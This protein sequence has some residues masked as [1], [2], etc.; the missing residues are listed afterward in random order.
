MEEEVLLAAGIPPAANDTS[1]LLDHGEG[2]KIDVRRAGAVSPGLA[3][4]SSGHGSSPREAINDGDQSSP[5][6]LHEELSAPYDV[7]LT[8]IQMPVM[9]KN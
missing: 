4:S 2:H 9:G 7:I 3:G 5:K 1:F 6:T 8:D